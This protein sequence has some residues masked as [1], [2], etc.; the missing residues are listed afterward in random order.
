MTLDISS[1]SAIHEISPLSP[2]PSVLVPA[3]FSGTALSPRAETAPLNHVPAQ[4]P[5]PH[6]R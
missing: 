2:L 5:P 3:I 1:G 6:D 4:T